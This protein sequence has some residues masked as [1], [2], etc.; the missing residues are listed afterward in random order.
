MFGSSAG[1]W[2]DVGLLYVSIRFDDATLLRFLRARKFD[3]NAAKAM[4]Q[5]NEEWRKSFKTDEIARSFDYPER[6]EVD[7]YYPQYYHRVDKVGP[8]RV[9]YVRACSQDSCC[10]R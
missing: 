4:W 5:A 6:A 8:S 9:S 3:I 7:K 2:T 1:S 10:P